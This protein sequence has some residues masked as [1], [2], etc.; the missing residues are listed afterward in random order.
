[1]SRGRIKDG[2]GDEDGGDAD[3]N[4]Q[5]GASKGKGKGKDKDVKIKTEILFLERCLALLKPGGRLGIVLPEGI[6]NN[7]SLQAVREFCED[8]AFIQAVISLPADTFESSKASVKVSLLFAQKFTVAQQAA[9]DATRA[10][11][12]AEVERRYAPEIE[13]EDRRL[14]QAITEVRAVGDGERAK[15]LQIRES[16]SVLKRQFRYPMFMY[17][18]TAVGI[19]ATGEADDNELYPNDRKPASIA[20]TCLE[21]Y[22]A[23]KAAYADLFEGGGRT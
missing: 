13:A 22:R 1:M 14:R 2:R 6:F 12:C 15:A 11:A 16:R 10:A 23:F 18:A 19:T 17:G 4:G 8:R 9:F 21:E 3:G 7:P 20:M 5:D